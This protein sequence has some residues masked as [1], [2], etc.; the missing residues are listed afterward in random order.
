MVQFNVIDKFDMFQNPH[1]LDSISD[2]DQDK[3][4]EIFRDKKYPRCE[5]LFA[6]DING[7]DLYF[8]YVSAL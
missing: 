8:S 4:D 2:E 6:P 3:I 1:Q 5:A 7:V